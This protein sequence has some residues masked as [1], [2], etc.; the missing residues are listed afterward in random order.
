MTMLHRWGREGRRIAG[1]RRW[2]FALLPGILFAA[3]STPEAAFA[4]VQA[5]DIDNVRAITVDEAVEIALRRNPTLLQAFSSIEMAEHN[6]LSAFGQLLPSVNMNFGYQNSS[7]GRID[8]LGEGIVATS[9]STRLTASYNLFNGWSRFTDLKGARLGVVEQNAR[10]REVE[11]QVIQQVKSQYA[12]TVAARELVSV[13][14]RRVQRQADQLEFVRQ[15]LELGRATRSDSLRSQVDLN[16]ARLALLNAEN[17]ARTTTFRLT[18]AVG[19]ETLVGPIAGAELAETPI[20]FTRDELFAMADV[21]APSLQSTSAAVEAAEAAVSSARSGYL[22][23]IFIGGGWGWSNQEFPPSNRSWQFSLTGSYPLFNGFQ[24]ETQVFRARATADQARQSERAAQLNISSELD[25]RYATA[26][27]ALAG[28]DL[29][30]Q[31]VELSEESLRVVQERY[32]L[33]LATILELQDAQITLTQAEVDLVTGRFDYEVAV[34][35]IE[36][37]LGRRLDQP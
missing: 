9:Y 25:A 2:G 35:A 17:N 30:S 33:G 11:F 4:Q 1:L 5:T 34:A 6:R 26:Q 8:P 24:R 29:A 20:T 28:V 18:E 23:S 14:Q 19:S 22:P 21:S 37:L 13:E 27:S 16:N 15:Q 36:A 12:A 7:T 32:R 31:N 3:A 10:Y